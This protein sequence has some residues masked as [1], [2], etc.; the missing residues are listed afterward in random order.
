VITGLLYQIVETGTLTTQNEDAVCPEVEL[1]V[2]G[3]PTLVETEYPDV[4][5][6]HLLQRANQVRDPGDSHVLRC[7]GGSLGDRSRDGSGAAFGQDDTV[8]SGAVGGAEESPKVMGVLNAIES[9]EETVLPILFWGE[10]IFNSEE[11]T[12]FHDCQH[13]LMGVR[14]CRSGELVARLK[15]HTDAGGPALLN[16]AFEAFVATFTGDAYMVEPTRT[17][18]DGLL[19][20]VKTVKNF[21]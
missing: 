17:G 1:G 4:F 7:S 5:L 18:T 21:H 10:E 2:V 15:R 11:L 9:E 13:A 8:D 3:R 20:R 19:D 16:E 6:F 14:F 12:L